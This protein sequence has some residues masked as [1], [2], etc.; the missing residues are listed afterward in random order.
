MLPVEHA[1]AAADH[2][3]ALLTLADPL[4]LAD[5]DMSELRVGVALLRELALADADPAPVALP[6]GLVTELIVRPPVVVPE[7][8]AQGVALLGADAVESALAV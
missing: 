8:L 1:L 2:D 3:T 4:A 5:D 7:E 6:V